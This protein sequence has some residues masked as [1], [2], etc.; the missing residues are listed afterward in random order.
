MLCY[1]EFKLFPSNSH[2]YN[3]FRMVSSKW[4]VFLVLISQVIT[5]DSSEHHGVKVASFKF[6][7]VKTEL[8]LAMFIVLIGIFKLGNFFVK[9]FSIILVYH[10]YK[11]PRELVPESCCL[12]I[13]GIM[14]GLFFL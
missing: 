14:L 5:V 10:H 1:C 8:I 7:Y 2:L 6:E 9:L 11:Y 13:I 3:Y 4:L 12:I